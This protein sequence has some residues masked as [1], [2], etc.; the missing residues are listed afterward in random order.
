MLDFHVL[1][2]K[3]NIEMNTGKI[4]I[5]DLIKE[6]NHYDLETEVEIKLVTDPHDS[7]KDI[8]LKWVGEIDTSR[9]ESGYIEFGVEKI[10]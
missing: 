2:I 1:S 7:E 8:P 5:K 9:L 10:K 3:K 4:K 6:L